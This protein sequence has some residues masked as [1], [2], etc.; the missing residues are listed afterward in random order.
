MKT[1]FVVDDSLTNL[2]TAKNTLE[3][4]YQAVTI[5]SA[6]KMISLL[7]KITPDLILL[8]IEMP[9]M[10]GFEALLYLKS[11][12]LY[13][14]IPVIFLTSRADVDVETR[15]FEQGVVDFITK[16]FSPPV[17][18]NRIKM[19]LG[20]DGIIRERTAQIR[21]LQDGIVTV[22]ADV[23]EER[24]SETGGHN[25]RT[26]AYI[27]ILI[28]AMEERG[29]YIDEM[30]GWNMEMVVS[31]ARLHDTGKIHISDAI[32]NKPGKLDSEEYEQMKSH[33]M[34]GARI[35]DRM[36]NQ[37]NEEEYLHNAN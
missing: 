34:E 33:S 35:L 16:P 23:V 12:S 19:H 31:S 21:R 15:G 24:D 17:L 20:I 14:N 10:D 37:T 27:R 3:G 22:L 32:L 11:S 6:T 4:S 29:V 26:S 8:D 18:L 7:G 28:K 9:E 25:D 36:I 1:I 30:R 13:A 5:P 2:V